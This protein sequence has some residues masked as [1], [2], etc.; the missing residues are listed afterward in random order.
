MVP[1]GGGECRTASLAPA[2][3]ALL[4]PVP[5]LGRAGGVMGQWSPRPRVP[6]ALPAHMV[7]VSPPALVSGIRGQRTRPLQPTSAATISTQH[8][9]LLPPPHLPPL[10]GLA[11][12]SSPR[13]QARRQR[14]PSS[15]PWP[16]APSCLQGVCNIRVRDSGAAVTTSA[17]VASGPSTGCGAGRLRPLPRSSPPKSSRLQLTRTQSARSGGYCSDVWPEAGG[18]SACF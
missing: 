18:C 7:A 10:T 2:G 17:T 14:R 6:A 5:A 13:P 12:S 1:D 16:Q 9:G 8:I 3:C 15:S 4:A 11:P